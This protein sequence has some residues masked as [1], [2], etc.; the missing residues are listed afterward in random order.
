MRLIKRL[1]VQED[2][3]AMATILGVIAVLTVTSIVLTDQVLSEF[4]NAT[5]AVN[6]NAVYQA[7]EAGIG[8][9][10]SKLNEDPLYFDHQVGKG[11]ATRQSCASYSNGSCISYGTLVVSP[12]ANGQAAQAW[13]TGTHWGY[14]NGA[15]NFFSGTGNTY[16]NSTVLKGYAYDLMV[17]PPSSSLGT[18][19]I[20]V[21]STGC[22]L[23]SGGTTCD[24]LT[25]KQSILTRV[26]RSNPANFQYM[27]P[28]MSSSNVCFAS[29]LYGIVYSVGTIKVCGADAYG[30]LLAET[31]VSGSVNLIS[32][33]KI[34][35][36][37]TNPSIRTQV[38]QPVSFSQLTISLA[39][40]KRAAALNSPT[41]VFDDSSAAAWQ[42]NFSSNGTFQ[43]WKCVF[44][45]GSGGTDPA[46]SEPYC[47]NLT[48]ATATRSGGTTTITTKGG[49][50]GLPSSGT[51]Y[52]GPNS[53]GKTDTFNYSSLS[54]TAT[55]AT[56]KGSP[57]LTFTH[58]ANER[59]SYYSSAPWAEPYYTGPLPPN[60]AI[61]TGQDA[62]VSWPT[63][64]SGSDGTSCPSYVGTPASAV[65]GRV[66]VGSNTD[67]I[68]AGDL[69][70]SSQ[71]SGVNDDVLG[72]VANG[73]VW[74][75]D[76]TPI[77]LW[78]RSA[79]IALNGTWGDYDCTNSKGSY[80]GSSSS[81]TFVGTAAY[82]SSSGCM[83]SG[84]SYGFNIDNVNRV[85]DDG[86]MA[87]INACPST[88]PDCASYNALQ[89]LFPPWFP[90]LNGEKI[91]LFQEVKPSTLLPVG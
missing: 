70:Y 2:G 33:A 86:S 24:P 74:I 46:Y 66:T 57:S 16:G 58:S 47:D 75:A 23:I 34:Y 55:T 64:V 25:P 10:V 76:Y 45:S 89:F 50:D 52:I 1:I 36:P 69:C 43:V 26:S 49:T 42:I 5:G 79:T 63:A 61:Y 27:V 71:A 38:P 11:E 15:D 81:M 30:N 20:S 59:V 7:A 32:P 9:Y 37:S 56:F 29:N 51:I 31:S 62:V 54:S 83:Q 77:N 84:T 91:G 18:T 12:V 35:T 40:L 4:H 13:K 44:V 19:Y 90:V 6:S 53:S 82:K 28:D 14:P 41:T 60:N 88:A 17:T 22:K 48:L 78:W 72:V 85:A 67:V 21:L 68:V 87:T 80:R 65:N 73:N 39:S 8:D 3:I